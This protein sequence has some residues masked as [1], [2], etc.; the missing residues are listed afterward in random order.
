[1]AESP[2]D[3][4]TTVRVTIMT[5]EEVLLPPWQA[6]E[7]ATEQVRPQ[8]DLLAAVALVTRVRAV[9]PWQWQEHLAEQVRPQH[10]L[11]VLFPPAMVTILRMAGEAV[12]A[13]VWQWQEHLPEQV[14]PQHDLFPPVMVTIERRPWWQWQEH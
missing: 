2:P 7:Q 3:L 8:Q 1:V 9:V 6:Q 11:V 12:M 13:V 4:D 10:D 5:G 14:R